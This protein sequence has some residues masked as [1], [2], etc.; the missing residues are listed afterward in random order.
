MA[1]IMSQNERKMVKMLHNAAK[2]FDWVMIQAI[3]N[4]ANATLHKQ[5]SNAVLLTSTCAPP[6]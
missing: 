5:T 2:E 3:S 6:S 4:S 1:A